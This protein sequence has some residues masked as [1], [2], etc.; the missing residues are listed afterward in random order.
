MDGR[1]QKSKQKRGALSG[2]ANSLA[3]TS[4]NNS[5][6]VEKKTSGSQQMNAAATKRHNK[7]QQAA[8]QSEADQIMADLEGVVVVGGQE[9]AAKQV[10]DET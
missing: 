9:P 4:F 6:R 1:R 5:L 10:A 3:T 7:M 2:A 8:A